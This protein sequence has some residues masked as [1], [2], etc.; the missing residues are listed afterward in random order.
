M[1]RGLAI[2]RVSLQVLAVALAVVLTGHRAAQA[3]PAQAVCSDFPKLSAEAKK[4]GDAVSAAL[5]AKIDHK[6]IC[7]LMGSFIIAEA[8]VVKFL[9]D[10]QTWCG[11]PA[12]AVSISVA[13]HEKSLKFRTAI[14]ADAPHQKPPSLSDA[15][16]APSIDNSTNTKTGPGTFDTLTGN[17]LAR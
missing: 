7:T 5:K 6:Q 8:A 13:N 3:Q 17:P 4:R 15:I 14:C 16:K 11:V 9:T 1:K 10:N 12:Q 2:V